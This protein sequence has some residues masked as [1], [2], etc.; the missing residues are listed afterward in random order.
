MIRK[1]LLLLFGLLVLQNCFAQKNTPKKYPSL[2][3]E[4]TGNGL[5]KPSYLFG[6]MHVSRKMAFHLSDSFYYA[7]KNADAVALELN[8]DIWQ[9]QMARMDKLKTEY[10][11][12]VR[13]ANG[14]FL[15]ENSFRLK[16]YD[17]ELKLALSTEPSVVNSLLYRSYK[18]QEDFE[19]DTFLDLYIFQTGKKLGKRGTG[20]ENYYETEKIV[21]E[22]YGDMASEK[23]KKTIDTDG[24]SMGDI[25]EKIED[26]Y[27]RGD[28]DLMDSLDNI[29]ERSAAFREKFLYLRNE[30]QAN[31]MDSIMKKSSLFAGVGSAH[32]PGP[33]GVIELLRNKGY[34]L[35]PIKMANRNATQKEAV[36][37]LKVPVIFSTINAEDGFYKVDVP[38]QLYD[39]NEDYFT[40]NRRQYS[41]MSNGSFYQV[42]R[43]KTHAAFINQ[44]EEQVKKKIDS[45]LYENIPGKISKKISITKNGY[46][47]YDITSRTRRGDLQRYHILITPVEIL[48][49]KMS[50]KE[51]YIDGKEGNQFFSSIT[52]KERDNN[53]VVYSPAAGG[54]SVK[55][56]QQ[57]AVTYEKA[58]KDG[59]STWTY[60]AVNKTTGSAY[61][62]IKKSIYNFDFLDQDSFELKLVEESFRSPDY[63]ERQVHRKL[64]SFNGYPRLEV[65]EKMKDSAVVMAHYLIKGPH[66]YA[67][68]IRTDKKEE[69]AAFFSSFQLTPY[70]YPAS[71]Q[72]TDTFMHFTANTPVAPAIDT[73][74][75]A[76]IEKVA[77]AARGSYY[78]EY[79]NDTENKSAYFF[80]DSTGEA[81]MV[82]IEK[83]SDYYYGK[84]T[85]AFWKSQTEGFEGSNEMVVSNKKYF[86]K[87]G[88]VKGYTLNVTDTGSSKKIIAAVLLKNNYLFNII[89]M[90]DTLDHQSSFTSNFFT[91]FT[92]DETAKG[93]DIF[94]NP[95]DTFFAH[96]F[97]TDS[98][99]LAKA[100]KSIG[101]VY[102]G[103]AGVPKIMDALK[104]LSP[105]YKN[106]FEVKT[107]LIAELGFIKDTTNPVVVDHLKSIY[108]Q[109]ADTSMFQNEAITALARHKTKYATSSFK[110]MVLQDPPVYDEDSYSYSSPFNSLEDTLELAAQLYPDILQ[111]TSLDD[112]KEPVMDLL[113][114][115]VD[116]GHIKP[117]QYENWFSK[118]FFDAKLALK[119]QKVNDEK[120]ME[121]E[122]KKEDD[123]EE[124]D[125]AYPARYSSSEHSDELKDYAVL[126]APFYDQNVN[127]SK[128]FDKLLQ[129]KDDDVKMNVAVVLLRNK[130]DV[131]DSIFT[132]IAAKDNLR[133]RLYTELEEIKRLDKFPAK[134]KNQVDIARTYLL[135]EKSFDKVDSV[136][137]VGKQGASYDTKKGVVYFFKYRVKKED[138]WKMGISGLQPENENE[139]SSDNKLCSMTDKKLKEEKP[140]IEQF[141]EQLKKLLFNFHPSARNFYENSRYGN[142]NLRY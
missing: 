71:S 74:Y 106:Y 97:S 78:N 58:G 34:K 67:L 77:K 137:L 29:V 92:A 33:R 141:Q 57:P 52:L 80:S 139:V 112:Y 75:R 94:T 128:F 113:V 35:R 117:A 134:Y 122:S 100:Q 107:K 101:E 59:N 142:Y 140:A 73:G 54:F 61:L 121:E 131:P 18:P 86:E 111:L 14:D 36:D 8:P 69:A 9:G 22:A 99:T 63:F 110:E 102:Y 19:E 48:I 27:K 30:I 104:K 65:E 56:P 115:L 64:S 55:L 89:T 91:S 53:N 10:S 123:I 23:K 7:I 85:A 13:S 103:E 32:L 50:G 68:A 132:N 49:F 119:K 39:V 15:S 127:V 135:M 40:L 24:E 2:L 124:S 109:T 125:Y 43:V 79:S 6:T 26:A 51:N 72:F 120:K 60:E 136:E 38:G 20:V 37:K 81:I 83:L 95:L 28:L 105:G 12:Y 70:R 46:S 3:W 47:G 45:L 118:I 90:G 16:K 4:I 96:L 62:I 129:S 108:T 130:R 1:Y 138:D 44:T 88:G 5:K 25:A 41:D 114:T 17:D 42:T 126:L 11:N 87:P 84:D 21:L 116:S 66:Y 31:S 98:G 76:V 82:S 93:R 133:G